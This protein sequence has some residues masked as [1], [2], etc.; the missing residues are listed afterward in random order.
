MGDQ[1]PMA[2][3]HKGGV[4]ILSYLIICLRNSASS[5]Q[6]P[7]LAGRVF[8]CSTRKQSAVHPLSKAQQVELHSHI[9]QQALF[10]VSLGP[11]QVGETHKCMQLTDWWNDGGCGNAFKPA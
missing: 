6:L 8:K 7:Q 2:Y 5:R 9:G 3:V 1:N 10:A 11:P 4:R